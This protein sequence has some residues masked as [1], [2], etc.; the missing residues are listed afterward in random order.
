MGCRTVGGGL[1]GAFHRASH[2]GLGGGR[3]V[4]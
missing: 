1:V 2:Q 3:V 4:G